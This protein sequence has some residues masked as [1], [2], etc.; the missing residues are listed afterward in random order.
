MYCL[1]AVQLAGT[2]CAGGICHSLAHAP[3]RYTSIYCDQNWLIICVS[4]P[5][6]AQVPSLDFD[7]ELLLLLGEWDRHPGLLGLAIVWLMLPAGPK[8]DQVSSLDSDF[9]LPPSLVPV[10]KTR[11]ISSCSVL[12]T[13]FSS[14]S[15]NHTNNSK[16]Q[17][18]VL[19]LAVKRW[20]NV[21]VLEL[22]FMS[23]FIEKITNYRVFM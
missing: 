17:H 15:P 18:S 20:W 14:S 11:R 16:L 2:G 5:K 10:I 23:D 8:A 19:V 6:A 4:G 9:E 13:V 22:L 7:F 1:F 12:Y 3:C 21:V